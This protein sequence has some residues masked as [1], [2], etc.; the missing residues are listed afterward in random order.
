MRDAKDSSMTTSY[1]ELEFGL[2][3]LIRV[4]GQDW[5]LRGGSDLDVLTAYT[6]ASP[7]DAM[8]ALLVDAL[9]L[10]DSPVPAW[11][12]EALWSGGTY[13]CH[14]L[15]REGWN[16]RD[17]LQKITELCQDR[18]LKDDPAYRPGAPADPYTH[19][20][21]AVLDGIQ[22][23]SPRLLESTLRHPD[24]HVPAWCR[25]STWS[26]PRR[27]ASSRSACS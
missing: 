18:L 22:L 13:R 7:P 26:P 3:S 4:F 27:R 6:V 2:M 21:G 5:R 15:A 20:T 24:Q 23:V 9:R 14:D 8:E 19:L 25:P 11:A 10:S 1:R 17:W 12:I 16:G